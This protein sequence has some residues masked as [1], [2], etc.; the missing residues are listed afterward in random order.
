M[1]A[2]DIKPE[3]E[4]FGI[5]HVHNALFFLEHYDF[6]EAPLHFSFVFG[7]MGGVRFESQVLS[8]FIQAVP[9]NSTWQG[10]GAGT[11]CFPV[12]MASAIFGGHIRVG[13]EDNIYID[14]VSKTK[15]KGNWD[16]VAKAVEIAK[17]AGRE[18]AS[19]EEARKMLNLTTK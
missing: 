12:A 2:N 8:S 1:R 7:V 4:C 3:I 5:S 6:L 17:M 13:L 15:C 14:L 9:P 16:Q 10:V 11:H 18:A 19:P